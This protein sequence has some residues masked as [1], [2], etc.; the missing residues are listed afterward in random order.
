L[1]ANIRERGTL[2]KELQHYES[3]VGRLM[4]K[5]NEDE[6]MH[7]NQVRPLD[8]LDHTALVIPAAARVQTKLLA[9]KESH[10]R[11]SEEVNRDLA[12]LPVTLDT[13]L[14]PLV[15]A[16]LD[17]EAAF[18]A[19]WSQHIRASMNQG[20]ALA[21]SSNSSEGAAVYQKQLPGA[22]ARFHELRPAS[23]V[24]A[25]QETERRRRLS[26][27]QSQ[28]M[29]PT[30]S[31]L[32]M[33][34]GGGVPVG[35]GDATGMGGMGQPMQPTGAQAVPLEQQQQQQLGG[36]GVGSGSQ[37]FGS[38]WVAPTSMPLTTNSMIVPAG[39]GTFQQG[40]RQGR[41]ITQTSALSAP[42]ETPGVALTGQSQSLGS[43]T[44]LPSSTTAAAGAAD[45]AVSGSGSGIG[46]DYGMGMGMGEGGSQLPQETHRLSSV[47]DPTIPASTT[48]GAY[49]AMPSAPVASTTSADQSQL[50]QPQQRQGS[51]G[52]LSGLL[53]GGGLF[54]GNKSQQ[55]P[56]DQAAIGQPSQPTGAVTAEGG[57][58]SNVALNGPLALPNNL[59]MYVLPFHAS[60]YCNITL[61]APLQLPHRNG[62][63][64]S[65]HC[66]T[67]W[68]GPH[69]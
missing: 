50:Q 35:G 46:K 2:S 23:L 7:V 54:G 27:G 8:K 24:A 15:A 9:V 33:A 10:R 3:K 42:L 21:G 29:V 34:A 4:L 6:H 49:P 20:P 51:G 22:L 64:L 55:Q 32:A 48:P 61:H 52:L 38:G 16:L 68:L 11:I 58:S 1:Q 67:P 40:Q 41:S 62:A 39:D 56:I 59:S 19:D 47:T 66:H 53:G 63:I 13:R 45:G 25:E 43:T 44:N 14:T 37:D 26:S 60:S 36:A 65:S 12:A 28:V 5:G 18:Y 69:G 30:G 17:V 57:S 31:L